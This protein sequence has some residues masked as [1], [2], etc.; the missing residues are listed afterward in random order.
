[1]AS[2]H[3]DA[4]MREAGQQQGT[5]VVVEQELSGGELIMGSSDDLFKIVR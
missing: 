4:R 5:D 1:V 3:N 2:K